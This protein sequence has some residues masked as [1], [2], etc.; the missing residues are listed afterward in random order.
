MWCSDGGPLLLL[1]Y[2]RH[3]FNQ[4]FIRSEGGG[5]GAEGAN[6]KSG[7]GDEVDEKADEGPQDVLDGVE[8]VGRLLLVHGDCSGQTPLQQSALVAEY[9][10]WLSPLVLWVADWMDGRPVTMATASH[11]SNVQWLFRQSFQ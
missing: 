4:V 3:K 5:E 10:R 11:W 7:E 9:D 8:L 1:S 2:W 6:A